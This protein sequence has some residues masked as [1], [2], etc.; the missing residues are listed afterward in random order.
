MGRGITMK[1]LV[2]YVTTATG[3][4]LLLASVV[5]ADPPPGHG[6]GQDLAVFARLA[7]EGSSPPLSGLPP[8]TTILSLRDLGDVQM[9]CVVDATPRTSGAFTVLNTTAKPIIVSGFGTLL[10]ASG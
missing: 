4:L 5:A 3:A 9:L 1:R 10:R 8:M 2:R 7:L 6:H